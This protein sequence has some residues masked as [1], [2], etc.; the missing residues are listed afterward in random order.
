MAKELMFRHSYDHENDVASIWFHSGP[1]DKI[2]EALIHGVN[3]DDLFVLYIDE[4][5]NKLRGL[6]IFNA[7][8]VDMNITLE[9]GQLLAQS[10][11]T[12]DDVDWEEVFRR[13]AEENNLITH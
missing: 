13:C 6:E 9:I 4:E 10:G 2:D 3:I 12:K 5:T 8:E 1:D 11:L 7:S